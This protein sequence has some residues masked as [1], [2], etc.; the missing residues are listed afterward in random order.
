MTVSSVRE[1]GADEKITAHRPALVRSVPVT[2]VGR[3]K[4][5]FTIRRDDAALVIQPSDP[6]PQRC[7]IRP[8]ALFDHGGRMPEIN[9]TMGRLL[10]QAGAS[11]PQRYQPFTRHAERRF[12]EILLPVETTPDDDLFASPARWRNCE[13]LANRVLR[14][15]D[16]PWSGLTDEQ[17]AA[18]LDGEPWL[19]PVEGCVLH[20]LTQW[21]RG[22]GDCVIEIGSLRGQSLS[23][24]ALA[25]HTCGGD[26]RIVSIDPHADHPEH[27]EYVR[28]ALSKIGHGD[29]L[30]QFRCSSDAAHSMLRPQSASLIFIDG[31][32]SYDQV[33]A[34]FRNYRD[35]LAPGGAMVFHDY[36][37]GVHNGR[38]D[39]CPNVRPAIDE[40]VMNA[41]GFKPLLLA[42]TLIAF[43]KEAE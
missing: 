14:A 37:Y 36:G 16:A 2:L 35:L 27:A 22:R 6:L 5:L 23:M 41:E 20:A 29:R 40:H 26:E 1:S 18:L 7:A 31:D 8:A 19:Q 3:A 42:H 32:H 12:L 17:I 24:I 30:V 34:D 13:F 15:A 10:F 28:L 39:V 43:V 25:L 11:E 38:P 4:E 33:V 21:V 9:T